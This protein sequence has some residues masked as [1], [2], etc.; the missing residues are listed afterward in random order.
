MSLSMLTR[1][2]VL[3]RLVSIALPASLLFAL[4]GGC[5]TQNQGTQAAIGTGVVVAASGINR[6]ATK[7]CWARCSAGYLCNQKTGLCEPGECT[8]ACPSGYACTVTP[9]E[10]RCVAQGLPLF[11]PVTDQAQIDRYGPRG[12]VGAPGESDDYRTRERNATR[13][14][15]GQVAIP[16][17]E[18]VGSAPQADPQESHKDKR[19]SGGSEEARQSGAQIFDDLE[20]LVIQWRRLQKTTPPLDLPPALENGGRFGS[21]WKPYADSLHRKLH[22]V[23]SEG[24]LKR[25]DEVSAT[26]ALQQSSLRA[27]LAIAL[28]G[29]TGDILH[30]E[31]LGSSD[32]ELFDVAA[33]EAVRR[34]S[35]FAVPPRELLSEDEKLYLTWELH[36]HID[37]AC[38]AAFLQL[39]IKEP[40]A[41][42][43]P[44]N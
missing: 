40:S 25:L 30:V 36:R 7:E 41:T 9:T 6:A 21:T 14:E 3:T 43:R 42:S 39:H 8:P 28:E 44:S 24:F 4:A 20:S 31:L 17:K 37:Y 13:N 12:S 26:H 10:T 18:V 1:Q 35:P 34:A 19:I 27:T 32:S 2:A 33:I 29:A 11:N 16:R 38:S 15:V 5:G 23:Y 22:G